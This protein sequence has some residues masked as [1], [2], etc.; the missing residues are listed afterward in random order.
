MGE[1]ISKIILISLIILIIY[2]IYKTFKQVRMD[3]IQYKN[4]SKRKDIEIQRMLQR[5]EEFEKQRQAEIEEKRQEQIMLNK[6]YIHLNNGEKY[7]IFKKD[8]IRLIQEAKN[9]YKFFIFQYPDSNG[10]D[11]EV[12]IF[13]H[14]IA[15][16]TR[17]I[18]K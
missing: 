11:R 10:Y 6:Y 2:Y 17:H 8:Y 4:H 1:I 5:Q 3:S 18:D 9:G 16:I 13:L 14:N 7:F 12:T 15:C